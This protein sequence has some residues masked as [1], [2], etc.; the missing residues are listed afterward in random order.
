M[1]IGSDVLRVEVHRK[2]VGLAEINVKVAK[3]MRDDVDGDDDANDRHQTDDKKY[4]TGRNPSSGAALALSE[5]AFVEFCGAP[6]N[7]NERP[8]VADQSAELKVAVVVKQNQEAKNDEEQA[9]ENTA[10]PWAGWRSV[11]HGRLFSL[12]RVGI[13]VVRRRRWWSGCHR[14]RGCTGCANVTV[15][16]R[17]SGGQKNRANHNKKNRKGVAEGKI[18]VAQFIQ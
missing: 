6:E 17:Q 18:A 13:G 2:R 15:H 12:P 14:R 10:G 16:R 5:S 11:G 8:P 4:F 9:A 1:R 3:L 7:K